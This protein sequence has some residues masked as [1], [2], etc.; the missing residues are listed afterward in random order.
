MSSALTLARPYAR[1]AFALAQRHACMPQWSAHLEFSA[2]V[3][4]DPRV[5]GLLDDPR[6][7]AA[8]L[9][10]LLAPPD[11][12]AAADQAAADQTAPN[13]DYPRF[14]AVLAENGRLA[15]LPEI[16][17]LY[18]QLRADAER[19]VKAMVTSAT[20]L[21]ASELGKLTASLKK[22]FGREVEV[23]TAVDPAL[24]GGAVIDTG[25]VVIDG[26]LRSKLARLESTLVH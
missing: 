2:Q 8:T 12:T 3:A 23:R 26:S 16:A 4:A 7:D 20:P 13:Q 5:Q 25:D 17:T 22:R 9:V 1:A 10:A 18:A 6:V 15:V 14:L 19:I 21:D 11:A 24:I